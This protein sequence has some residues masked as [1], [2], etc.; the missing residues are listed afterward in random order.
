MV[1]YYNK[2][3]L[4]SFGNYLLSPHR[5]ALFALHPDFKEND[6]EERLSNVHHSDIENW[7]YALEQIK[8]GDDEFFDIIGTKLKE[9]LNREV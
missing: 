4:V 1:T 8:K 7:K 3:D 2:K 9:V 6:L 5:R